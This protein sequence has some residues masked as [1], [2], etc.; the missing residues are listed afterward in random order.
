VGRFKPAPSAASTGSWTLGVL[1]DL[2]EYYVRGLA[3][4]FREPMPD[5][6]TVIAGVGDD[7]PLTVVPD[8]AGGVHQ[9]RLRRSRRQHQP[10]RGSA[11]EPADGP[12]V[13]HSGGAPTLMVSRPMKVA[14]ETSLT[15]ASPGT[16]CRMTP[17]TSSFVSWEGALQPV[18][19]RT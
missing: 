17:M 3:I 14:S 15:S 5:Q 10:A 6:D 4:G 1:I 9:S 13:V 11:A 18:P 19:N 8:A 2:A 12:S 7:H 16:R